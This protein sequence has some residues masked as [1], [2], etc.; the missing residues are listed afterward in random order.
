[1]EPYTVTYV[2]TGK[3]IDFYICQGWLLP[4]IGLSLHLYFDLYCY[5][6][7]YLVNIVI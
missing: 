4:L 2:G 1:M 5:C 3:S 7:L 6:V